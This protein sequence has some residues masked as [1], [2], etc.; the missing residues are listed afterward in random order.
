MSDARDG[1]VGDAQV[2]AWLEE[3]GIPFYRGA[4]AALGRHRLPQD[5]P[6]A[7]GQE[8]ALEFVRSRAGAM[9]LFAEGVSENDR[10]KL[11]RASGLLAGEG[12]TPARPAD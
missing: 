9:T 6:L 1:Q 4:E 2:I 7:D 11:E 12:R 3:D 5:S 10:D 8:E